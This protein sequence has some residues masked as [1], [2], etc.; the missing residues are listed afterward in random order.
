MGQ[1]RTQVIKIA[2]SG[3]HSTGKTTFLKDL[4]D[5]CTALG[6]RASL[7]TDPET[8][9]PPGKSRKLSIAQML[10][11][12]QHEMDKAQ[13]HEYTL[14]CI[15]VGLDEFNEPEDEP[16]RKTLMPGVFKVLKKITFG[17]NIQ[18]LGFWTEKVVVG[19]FPHVSPEEIADLGSALVEEAR[20]LTA[21]TADGGTTPITLSVGVAHNQHSGP[22]SFEILLREAETG[23][24]MAQQ[25]GGDR[26]VQWLEVESELDRLREELEEQIRQVDKR[27]EE[28][29]RDQDALAEQ[30]G[31]AFV[32]RI[33]AVFAQEEQSASSVRLEKAMIELA[34]N[35]VAEWRQSNLAQQLTDSNRQIENLERRVRKLTELLDVTESELRRVASMKN[36]DTGIASIF[37]TVQGLSLEDPNAELKQELMKDI[38]EAN[39][40]L[41]GRQ[42]SGDDG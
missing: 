4:R 25:G 41:L 26:C 38:F 13:R 15:L 1:D 42:D 6:L 17:S 24:S 39:L 27:H 32:T 30:R 8:S 29:A 20:T 40:A 3:A 35:E 22:M 23:L 28:F 14:S 21:P 5:R 12:M 2:V 18:G 16:F 37:R 31:K 34:T 36:I 11:L 19:V 9:A 33:Q 7:V 10:H